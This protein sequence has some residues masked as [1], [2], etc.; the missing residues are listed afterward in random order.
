MLPAEKINQMPDESH[1]VII[2]P[3]QTPVFQLGKRLQTAK[4]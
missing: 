3:L 2:H 1:L 4:V